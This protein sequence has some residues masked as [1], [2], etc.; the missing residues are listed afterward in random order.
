MQLRQY[1]GKADKKAKVNARRKKKRET[2]KKVE[3]QYG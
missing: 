2:K 3:T 1:T